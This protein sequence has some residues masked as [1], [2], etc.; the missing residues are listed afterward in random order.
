MKYYTDDI[1]NNISNATKEFSKV[2]EEVKTNISLSSPYTVTKYTPSTSISSIDNDST[3]TIST[4]QSKPKLNIFNI[5]SSNSN[6]STNNS[7]TNIFG[8][9]LVI[10]EDLSSLFNSSPR[11]KE[12]SDILNKYNSFTDYTK[13]SE[14]FDTIYKNPNISTSVKYALQANRLVDGV[15]NVISTS[16]DSLGDLT[17]HLFIK[18]GDGAEHFSYCM[19]KINKEGFDAFLNDHQCMEY[20]KYGIIYGVIFIGIIMVVRYVLRKITRVLDWL[21]GYSS[22]KK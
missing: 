17:G 7:F 20:V 11:A 19:D 21:S 10:N 8:E 3:N 4:T 5:S 15:G 16:I 14:Y 2:K 18:I 9:S 6:D 1:K 12:F 22:N 13:R